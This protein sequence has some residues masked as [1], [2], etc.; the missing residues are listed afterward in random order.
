MVEEIFARI[1]DN[2]VLAD[3]WEEIVKRVLDAAKEGADFWIL[4]VFLA[5]GYICWLWI[6]TGTAEQPVLRRRLSVGA[7]LAVLAGVAIWIKYR[8]SSHAH[9]RR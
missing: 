8:H 4:L 5:A 3:V 2:L 6:G 1:T 7:V 9:R